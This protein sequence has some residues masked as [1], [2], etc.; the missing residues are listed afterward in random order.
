[1][2]KAL[3]IF[4]LLF[5]FAVAALAQLPGIPPPGPVSLA[6]GGVSSPLANDWSVF[7]NPAG[8]HNTEKLTGVFSYQT[9]FNFSPFNTVAAAISSPTQYG[10]ASFG[11][12]RFGDDIFSSQ[13]ASLGFAKKIGIMS[14]GLKANYLQYNIET[15]GRQSVFVADMGGI[16]ELSPQFSFGI[17]IYNFT[18]SS[19]T[20][21]SG[22]KLP[23]IIRLAV[24]YKASADLHLFLEGEKDVDLDA[25][26]KFGISY[27]VIDALNLRTGFSTL[28]NKASYG[29]GFKINRFSVDYGLRANRNV[30]STHNFGLTFIL[31]D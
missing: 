4:T 26:I 18:Q 22:E 21:L 23:T 27:Q 28:T 20:D 15:F 19:I 25:D 1:M 14:L 10:K 13:M 5:T 6:L 11:V 29:L 9:I 17:H 24:D 30:G 2:R 31:S 8:I 16:A 12:Y 7:N 3:L